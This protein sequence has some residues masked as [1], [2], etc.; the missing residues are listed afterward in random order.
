MRTIQTL[1]AGVLFSS[2]SISAIAQVEITSW[3]I[4]TDGTTGRHYVSGNPTPIMDTAHANVQIVQYSNNFVYVHCSGIP[5]Y[6]IGPYLDGN[7]AM[8]TNREHLFQIP[9]NPVPNNGT[10][11]E[12]GLGSTGVFINGVPS[13][14]YADAMS[15]N[16]LGIWHRNAVHFENDGFDCAKGHPSPVFQGP[17]GPGGTLEGGQ[18]HH[19]Q[20]PSAYNIA[21]V[22]MSSVCDVYLADGLYVPDETQHSP[23]IGYAFDGYPIYGGYGYVNADGSGGIVRITPSWQKRNI[24]DRTTLP[25]GTALNTSEYGPSFIDAPLGAYAED[26][27][28]IQGSGMLDIH[29]GRECV[30]PEYPNGTYAYFATIDTDGNSVFPYIIGPT[31]YGIV[32]TDNFGSQ[33]TTNSTNVTIDEPVTTYT[34][35]VSLDELEPSDLEIITY[36]NPASDILVIQSTVAKPFDRTIEL[37]DTNGKVITG[38]I[39]HQGSTMCY[40]DV[41]ILYSGTY[42]VKISAGKVSTTSKV[43]IQ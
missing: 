29:N 13:Y 21:S 23:L 11:T 2:L 16:D 38:Q 34:P 12:V 4:N 22:P 37:F 30:T 9:R 40:F 17:P 35:S 28:F 6:V 3:L 1:F 33:G 20:N 32:E 26:Y 25:D 31:Y 42:L 24:T 43:I 18:Y 15:Y 27:E 39:L 8:A 14:N 5:S 19:H 7:P 36:P 10:L 41:S